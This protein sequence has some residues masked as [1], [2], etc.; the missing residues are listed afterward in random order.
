MEVISIDK[1]APFFGFIGS[2]EKIYNKDSL[3]CYTVFYEKLLEDL[4]LANAFIELRDTSTIMPKNYRLIMA[5]ETFKEVYKKYVKNSLSSDGLKNRAT[6][7]SRKEKASSNRREKRKYAKLFEK[8]V[9]STKDR[10][11]NKHKRIFFMINLYK[12][13]K[14]RFLVDW[15]G[16][17]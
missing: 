17:F 12:E 15:G 4:D 10:I 13:N 2:F 5:E 7:V 14:T 3:H 16:P 6:E 9:N 1:P 11:F 8:T